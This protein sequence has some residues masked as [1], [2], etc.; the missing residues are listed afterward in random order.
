MKCYKTLLLL[1]FCSLL[2]ACGKPQLSPAP[3][4]TVQVASTQPAASGTAEAQ[5]A[6]TDMPTASPQAS[7]TAQA[8]PELDPSEY[9]VV[10]RN[11]LKGV[12]NGLGSV[13]LPCAYSSVDILQWTDTDGKAA[14][15]PVFIAVPAQ[16]TNETGVKKA[17]GILCNVE[18]K[19]IPGGSFLYAW[20]AGRDILRVTKRTQAGYDLTGIL[21][22][23]GETVVPCKYYDVF[24]YDG[25]FAAVAHDPPTSEGSFVRT[26]IYSHEGKIVRS[27]KQEIRSAEGRLL[28]A[29]DGKTGKVGLMDDRFNW[30]I[31][32]Q[33]DW[34]Y[35]AGES[36]VTQSGGKY[37]LLDGEGNVKLA[38]RYNGIEAQLNDG[39]LAIV[40]WADDGVAL[41]DGEGNA[42]FQSADYRQLRYDG[43]VLFATDKSGRMH[44]LD[45]LGKEL[46]PPA[47]YIFQVRDYGLFGYSIESKPYALFYTREG[48]KLPLPDAESIQCIDPDRFIVAQQ[49]PQ[50]YAY[51]LCDSQ[52]NEVAPARYATMNPLDRDRLIVF[53]RSEG[54]DGPVKFGLMDYDGN[55]LLDA[56]YDSL[57]GAPNQNLLYAQAGPFNGLIDRKGNWV[58]SSSAYDVLDD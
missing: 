46:L 37:G 32:A 34:L 5:P 8:T 26:D 25:G 55:I 44:A 50:G 6:T 9:Y 23:A 15:D 31:P 1:T 2:A 39:E 21:T 40:A 29:Y 30:V 16:P 18:G 22:F 28:L 12:V 13:L 35:A 54:K 20:P 51:G 17:N 53:G 58:W 52:G 3:T 47:S 4:A 48:K 24:L 41:Y 43:G 42:L 11:G 10:D 27:G 49:G 38:A 19:Q 36:Y 57:W 33:W 45:L 14:G 56:Q 7:A